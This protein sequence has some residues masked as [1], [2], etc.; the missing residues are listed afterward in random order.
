MFIK[1]SVL[2]HR[3][4]ILALEFRS[5]SENV[6]LGSGITE[7]RQKM[8]IWN[9]EMQ[10]SMAEALLRS[11]ITDDRNNKHCWGCSKYLR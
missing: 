4:F 1:S 9:S 7:I 3:M 5:R 8:F 6:Y 10:V 11:S 2:A